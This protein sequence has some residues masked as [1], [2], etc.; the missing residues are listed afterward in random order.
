MHTVEQAKKRRTLLLL[1]LFFSSVMLFDALMIFNRQ[2]PQ[3]YQSKAQEV[4][5]GQTSNTN[6]VANYMDSLDL[7]VE[8]QTEAI[9]DLAESMQNNVY[10]LNKVK[11]EVGSAFDQ[12]DLVNMT[13]SLSRLTDIFHEAR[14]N[15]AA[16]SALINYY[17]ASPSA[18]ISGFPSADERVKGVYIAQGTTTQSSPASNNDIII[19]NNAIQAVEVKIQSVKD[20]NFN[21]DLNTIINVSA[22]V[23]Q[24]LYEAR[25]ESNC[26]KIRDA[27]SLF[28]PAQNLF[29][30]D[31]NLLSDVEKAID[32]LKTTVNG[33]Q[34]NNTTLPA[35]LLKKINDA[36]FYNIFITYLTTPPHSDFRSSSGVGLNLSRISLA[37]QHNLKI[38]ANDTTD[39]QIDELIKSATEIKTALNDLNTSPQAIAQ[40]SEEILKAQNQI[41][42]DIRKAISASSGDISIDTVKAWIN[43]AQGALNVLTEESHKLTNAVS[44]LSQIENRIS[45]IKED[46]E[47][48]KTTLGSAVASNTKLTKLETILNEV[49][50]LFTENK[51]A[52]ISTQKAI[53]ETITSISAFIQRLSDLLT[54]LLNA[55]QRSSTQGDNSCIQHPDPK[56]NDAPPEGG[57]II[58]CEDLAVE[59]SC[60]YSLSPTPENG[61]RDKDKEKENAQYKCRVVGLKGGLKGWNVGRISIFGQGWQIVGSSQKVCA[62]KK[63]VGLGKKIL[64]HAKNNVWETIG[65]IGVGMTYGRE[66]VGDFF[67]G[68]DGGND[69][70]QQHEDNLPPDPYKK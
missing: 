57:T 27:S 36:G 59:S 5:S 45:L 26:D 3:T 58:S 44:S 68:G 7:S 55:I 1:V 52:V 8:E 31:K 46:K 51:T 10:Q 23:D 9:G 4:P 64:L 53:G 63:G 38:C 24:L 62:C 11:N 30:N 47:K 19:V 35:D 6:F 56:K 41:I 29:D 37:I 21:A 67:G 14:V 32:N 54:D 65:E 25:S 50:R 60:L 39:K 15:V 18:E 40:K 43:T 17:S 2:E 33:I 22:Q 12:G 16:T 28:Q 69:K 34:K 61:K 13:V 42:T 70:P 48:I 49:D 66:K 20:K